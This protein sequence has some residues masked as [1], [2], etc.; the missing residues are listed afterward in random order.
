MKKVRSPS[1]ASEKDTKVRII[2]SATMLF[3][4]KGFDGTSVRNIAA[5]AKVNL[6]AINYHFSNK[7]NLY[8]D[9]L[10]CGFARFNEQVEMVGKGKHN[11]TVDFSIALYDM[12]LKNGPSLLN[13][14]KVLLDNF[15]FP[16]DI[17]AQ[18]EHAGPPGG[19]VI[20]DSLNKELKKNATLDDKLWAVRVIFTYV[21]HAALI[22]STSYAKK[23]SGK[24][25]FEK[26]TV[27]ASI[28]KLVE[29]ILKDLK[30]SK[31]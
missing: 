16:D 13:N 5:H 6:A 30:S 31:K 26:K 27:H 1:S 19:H 14:F 18:S 8:K 15:D 20:L 28:K 7:E 22:A 12:L 11:S 17:V 3:A 25:M 4:K 10:R 24:K 23:D 9:V 2:N 29:M 21:V